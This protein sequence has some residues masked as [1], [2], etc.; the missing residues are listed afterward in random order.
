MKRLVV[1]AS[2]I[3]MY[4]WALLLLSLIPYLRRKVPLCV[5]SQNWRR[6]ASASQLIDWMVG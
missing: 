2:L 5:M 6:Y 1:D 4:V 3:T